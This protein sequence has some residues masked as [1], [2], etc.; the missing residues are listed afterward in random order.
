SREPQRE[1]QIDGRSPFRQSTA[2]V[3][4]NSKSLA[5]ISA[6]NGKSVWRVGSSG[7]IERSVD[8][9]AT[10]DLQTSGLMTDLI[11]GSAPSDTV[12]WI[13]GQAGTILRT[14]DGGAHW[15]KVDPPVQGNF[16]SVFAVNAQ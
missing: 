2:L 7:L 14:T 15:A 10:W 1:Q 9:G 8:T 16:T 4:A 6:P 13:V 12:C 5:T 11:A 3:L